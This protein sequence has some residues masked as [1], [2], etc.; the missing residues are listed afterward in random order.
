M[1]KIFHILVFTAIF[2]TGCEERVEIDH[3]IAGHTYSWYRDTDSGY[4]ISYIDFHPNGDFTW[5][6]VEHNRYLGDESGRYTQMLWRVEGNNITVINNYHSIFDD[7]YGTVEY[8]GFYNPVDSTVT[9]RG[10]GGTGIA[11]VYEFLE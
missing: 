10:L 7:P 3:P 8:T 2:F 4:Y 11:I 6:F 5:S 9:L 1:K